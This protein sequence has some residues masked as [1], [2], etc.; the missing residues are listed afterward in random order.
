[1][2]GFKENENV[3]SHPNDIE[4]RKGLLQLLLLKA[5]G[6]AE[7]ILGSTPIDRIPKALAVKSR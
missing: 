3:N 2:D 4:N 6:L 5:I 7:D 1:M